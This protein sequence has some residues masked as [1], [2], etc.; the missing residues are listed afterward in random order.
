M[1]LLK[2]LLYRAAWQRLPML[3]RMYS[4]DFDLRDVNR[5]TETLMRMT[6]TRCPQGV[7]ILIKRHRAADAHELIETLPPPMRKRRIGRRFAGMVRSFLG[8]TA[9]DPV[10]SQYRRERNR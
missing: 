5:E 3:P 8:L 9:Y 10:R 4:T 6:H 7:N 1:N 2:Y